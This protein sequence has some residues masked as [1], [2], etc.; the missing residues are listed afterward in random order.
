MRNNAQIMNKDKLAAVKET[1]QKL[2]KFFS[3]IEAVETFESVAVVDSN[4]VIQYG[5]LE[6]GSDVSISTSAGSEPAPD[7]DYSLVNGVNITVADGKISN[8]EQTGD[9]DNSTDADEELA[10][11]PTPPAPAD[12]KKQ[13][14]DAPAKP[15][16]DDNSD[17]AD[18][19][20][21]LEEA[22][23]GLTSK[24]PSKDQLSAFE[25]QLSELNKSIADL[26]KIPTQFSN[27][28]RVEVKQ[29]E[30]DKYR[31]IANRYS[32]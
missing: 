8:I 31:Q 22:I 27:D 19:V 25:N 7:G 29:D 21:K 1:A 4:D 10:T 5:S 6:V 12:D 15:S 9:D 13:A 14:P 3:E 26:A 11:P 30:M 2:L 20:S 32:K 23:K 24:A 17:L 16:T 28:N 18:R